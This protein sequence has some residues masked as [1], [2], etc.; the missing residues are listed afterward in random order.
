M[1]V[2]SIKVPVRKTLEIY[3]MILVYIKYIGFGLVWFHG[4]WTILVYLMPNIPYTYIE[5]Q[6]FGLVWFGLVW[7]YGISTI[8]GFFN[9]ESFLYIYFKVHILCKL[10][11]VITF[12]N[13]LE[14]NILYTVK[15]FQEFLS[16]TNIS[17]YF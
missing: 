15:W 6:S 9:T 14:I 5:Y 13:Q 3:V 17:I 16:N 8:V 10:I 12:L 7:F 4:I 2:L 11:L 1:C